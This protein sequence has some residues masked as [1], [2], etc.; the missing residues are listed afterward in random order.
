MSLMDRSI[1]LFLSQGLGVVHVGA[2]AWCTGTNKWNAAIAN[3]KSYTCAFTAVKSQN[4]HQG[5][6]L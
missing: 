2:L 4:V 5:K 1:Q 6:S 3:I